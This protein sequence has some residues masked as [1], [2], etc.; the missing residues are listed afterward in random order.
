M[1]ISAPVVGETWANTLH[2]TGGRHI[3]PAEVAEA[4]NTAASGPVVEGCVGGGTGMRAFAF[5]AGIGTSSRQVEAA[6]TPY[7]VGVLV[8]ANVGRRSELRVD[9][10]RRWV[11]RSTI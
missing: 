2:D 4:L 11:N 1:P 7:Q 8:Q 9:G 6:S 10:V 3:G 5:K